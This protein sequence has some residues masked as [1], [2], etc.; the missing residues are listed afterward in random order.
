MKKMQSE[1][2][3]GGY[4][5]KEQLNYININININNKMEQSSGKKAQL[6]I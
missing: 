3:A 5:K 2:V 4:P 6:I 1:W